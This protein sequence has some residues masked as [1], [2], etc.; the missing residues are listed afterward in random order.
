V[1]WYNDRMKYLVLLL[2]VGCGDVAAAHA[3][4]QGYASSTSAAGGEPGAGG[5][6]GE[7]GTGGAAGASS[8]SA[9]GQGGE[10]GTGGSA[11]SPPTGPVVLVR[12]NTDLVI[13]DQDPTP[14]LYTCCDVGTNPDC[15]SPY[16]Y[17]ITWAGPNTGTCLG[18]IGQSNAIACPP[19]TGCWVDK[20]S[21][22]SY[23][24][25]CE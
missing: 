16:F 10:P 22:G 8:S 23:L 17:A 9:G 15:P 13:P 4:A 20:G 21:G 19:G 11:G 7:P 18:G 24:G 5:Q 2:L 14:Q 25:T 3:P 1:S 12:C 6:G